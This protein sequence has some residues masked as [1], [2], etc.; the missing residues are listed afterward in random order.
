MML[1][2]KQQPNG[3]WY[4]EQKL[5]SKSRVVHIASKKK[6]ADRFVKKTMLDEMR[7]FNAHLVKQ[8]S[9]SNAG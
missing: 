8:W 3:L 4:V 9:A 7:D 5:K 6:H 2:V 1:T